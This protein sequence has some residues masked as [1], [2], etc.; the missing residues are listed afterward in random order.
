MYTN[1]ENEK[2]KEQLDYISACKKQA[3]SKE[4][5]EKL[6]A[7]YKIASSKLISNFYRVVNYSNFNLY[8]LALAISNIVSVVEDKN[9]TIDRVITLKQVGSSEYNTA[10]NALVI[11]EKED[12]DAVYDQTMLEKRNI[13]VLYET[14]GNLPEKIDCYEL[15]TDTQT[16]N[17]NTLNYDH[18]TGVLP[19][20]DFRNRNYLY[21]FIDEAI[22]YK[23]QF[24]EFY[25]SDAELNDVANTF[26]FNYLKSKERVKAEQK[27][28]KIK[29]KDRKSVV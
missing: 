13:I 29:D 3:T 25:I 9:M 7:E 27:K 28:T 15:Q 8:D 21:M 1:F 22:A 20:I 2:L 11:K 14:L 5:L 19:K 4:D 24:G 18:I 17:A 23:N 6:N 16:I 26:T 12:T 10:Y